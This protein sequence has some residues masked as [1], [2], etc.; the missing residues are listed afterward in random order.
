MNTRR[1]W[2]SGL[3]LL[4]LIGLSSTGQSLEVVT[5]RLRAQAAAQSRTI[6]LGDVADLSGGPS[7]LREQLARLDLAEASEAG[8]LCVTARQVLIRLQ[9]AGIPL[10]LVRI[11]GEQRV[12]VGIRRRSLTAEEIVATA[13]QALLEQLSWSA[14]EVSIELVQ[15][16]LAPLPGVADDEEWLIKAELQP[17]QRPPGRVQMN[18]RIYIQGRERLALP[19]YFHVR[20]YAPVVVCRYRID[21]GQRLTEANTI[22]EK[23][24]LDSFSRQTI[25][26][27]GYLEKKA[28]QTILPGQ[29]IQ[30]VD[31]EEASETVPVVIK[32]QDAVKLQIRIGNL[33]LT[34]AGQALQDGRLGQ[35]IRVQ[36]VDSKKVLLGRVVDNALVEIE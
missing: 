19:V 10:T 11:E 18:T 26:P 14:D 33:Q 25:S 35:L 32:A 2:L 34:A 16:I 29:V 15:P 13:R 3:G 17:G 7:L 36:N 27:I 9:L 22:V 5:I 31:V 4:L 24:P 6:K 30:A 1:G 12:H 28:R 8:G 21:R 20:L 23:R